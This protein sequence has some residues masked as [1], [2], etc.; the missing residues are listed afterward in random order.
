[1]K[2][3]A[4]IVHIVFVACISAAN[5]L[6]QMQIIILEYQYQMISLAL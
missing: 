3:G 2:N 6:A 1:M 4:L 5:G